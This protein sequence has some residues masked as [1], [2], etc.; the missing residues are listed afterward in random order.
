[1]SAFRAK[2]NTRVS[3]NSRETSQYRDKTAWF[4]RIINSARMQ[5]FLHISFLSLFPTVLSLSLSQRRARAR[6]RLRACAC[7]RVP[8][9]TWLYNIIH[10]SLKSTRIYYLWSILLEFHRYI[11]HRIA[12]F[13]SRAILCGRKTTSAQDATNIYTSQVEIKY[14]FKFTREIR[15]AGMLHVAIAT[16]ILQMHFEKKRNLHTRLDRSRSDKSWRPRAQTWGT[17]RNWYR[18]YTRIC[19]CGTCAI[20]KIV[21]SRGILAPIL[22]QRECS[23]LR[24]ETRN[25]CGLSAQLSHGVSS[26]RKT[27]RTALFNVSRYSLCFVSTCPFKIH[28]ANL[29]RAHVKIH[30]VQ[31]C[32]RI[33]VLIITLGEYLK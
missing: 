5:C 17:S 21:V 31:L 9:V 15:S 3:R 28:L 25:K 24:E 26:R 13:M 14:N 22:R 33:Y 23:A 6:A 16:S 18:V 4:Q 1:M 32:I 7:L 8:L 10:F 2:G 29:T 19:L 20:C 11:L 12:N 27:K 30:L